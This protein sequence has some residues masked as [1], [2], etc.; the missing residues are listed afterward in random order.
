MAVSLV[1][2]TMTARRQSPAIRD[3]FSYK[4]VTVLCNTESGGTACPGFIVRVLRG[5]DVPDPRTKG[6]VADAI[7]DISYQ[8]LA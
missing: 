3:T 2:C 8:R 4:T 5:G 6:T 7:I 1:L